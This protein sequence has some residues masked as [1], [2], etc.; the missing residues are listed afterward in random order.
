MN[1]RAATHWAGALA[2]GLPCFY[3]SWVLITVWLDPMSRDQGHWIAFGPGLLALE[4][5]VLHSGVFI[6]AF[7]GMQ[8]E[9]SKRLTLLAGLAFLYAAMAFGITYAVGGYGLIKVFGYVMVGR[10]VMILADAD[11]WQMIIARSAVGIPIYM[12][13]VMLTV[14]VPVPEFGVT[15]NLIDAVLPD[16]SDAVWSLYPERAI[17]GGVLY[18][19]LMGLAELFL[20]GPGLERSGDQ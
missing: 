15:E 20:F 5:I 11:A 18:F 16:R 17:A 6:G 13:I 4:F 7:V 10:F 3:V 19:A 9:L 1:T 2:A 14:F 12:L 8:K